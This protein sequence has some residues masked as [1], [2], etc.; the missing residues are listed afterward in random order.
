MDITEKYW[1]LSLASISMCTSLTGTCVFSLWS[2]TGMYIFIKIRHCKSETVNNWATELA[3]ISCIY[4][5][6][7]MKGMMVLLM[8][9]QSTGKRSLRI[10][11]MTSMSAV[12]KTCIHPRHLCLFTW[13]LDSNASYVSNP[14]NVRSLM[15]FNVVLSVNMCMLDLLHND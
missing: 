10:G 4:T 11:S 7:L 3:Y 14:R 9:H 13:S 5:Y 6:H 8:V 15:A 2:L 12:G 1:I